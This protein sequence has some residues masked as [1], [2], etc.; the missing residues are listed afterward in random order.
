MPSEERERQF[1]RALERH[2]RG[3]SPD[4][5]C[6]DAETLAAYHEQTLSLEELAN[7][8]EHI[9]GC[10]R[11]QETLALVEETNTIAAHG[12]E[13]RDSTRDAALL[14]EAANRR[15]L[16]ALLREETFGQAE[17]SLPEVP[18][19]SVTKL[20]ESKKALGRSSWKWMAPV[21]ALAAG[22]LVFVALRETDKNAPQT[23]KVEVAQ[24]REVA[25]PME[26]QK[27]VPQTLNREAPAETRQDAPAPAEKTARPGRRAAPAASS[28]APSQ[29]S[30]TTAGAKDLDKLTQGDEASSGGMELKPASPEVA[31]AQA[32]LRAELGVSRDQSAAAKNAPAPVARVAGG[33]AAAGASGS[34]KESA[35]EADKVKAAAATTEAVMNL[36]EKPAVQSMQYSARVSALRKIAATDPR[37]ILAPDGE[38]AWR[39]GA[40][41]VIEATEDG[42]KS[43][44][45]QTSG[46][47]SELRNGSAPSD[48]VCWIVGK[49]GTILV[50]VDGGRHW[51]QI[52]S[53]LQEDLG[54]VHAV[55]AKHASIWNLS[56]TRSFET[57]DGGV[58]WT[59]AANE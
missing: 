48:N 40:T 19:V 59:P 42:G 14:G 28:P 21:G 4:A 10:V 51:N 57:A 25:A 8:K 20:P 15:R 29:D 54:G 7:W 2:L 27:A 16:S 18:I 24:N 55:T 50:T 9:G 43:W 56:N 5:A 33:L 6:P 1:E 37:M 23:T 22:L 12:S 3:A 46:V 13:D 47:L 31:R 32:Q 45:L 35:A 11:C 58:T 26:N 44:K 53:P 52:N 38:H 36:E 41:G 39:L 34:K 30:G 49:V 17:E